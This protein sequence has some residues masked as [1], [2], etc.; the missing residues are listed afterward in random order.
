MAHATNSG[1]ENLGS[2][3]IYEQDLGR[4]QAN[5]R[6]LSPLNY[7]ARSAGVYRG[8]TAVVHGGMRRSYAELYDRCR[9]LAAA[10][11]AR[12]RGG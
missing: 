8:R 6:P 7:L 2:A 1:D 11:N 4:N 12:H 9:C 3:N 5:H 10:L